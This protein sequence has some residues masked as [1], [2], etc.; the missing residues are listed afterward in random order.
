M[1]E[2]ATQPDEL[3]RAIDR[4]QN[5]VSMLRGSAINPAVVTPAVD[6]DEPPIPAFLDDDGE[7]VH[8]MWVFFSNPYTG[9]AC[10]GLGLIIGYLVA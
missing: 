5:M 3:D 4:A 10:F 2:I 1:S 6:D 7:P 8:P 9:L